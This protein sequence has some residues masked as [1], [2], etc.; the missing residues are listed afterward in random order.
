LPNGVCDSLSNASTNHSNQVT[1]ANPAQVD[2]SQLSPREILDA[3]LQR[4]KDPQIDEMVRALAAK[5]PEEISSGIE[6]EKRARSLVSRFLQCCGLTQYVLEP[7]RGDSI[8]DLVLSSVP[9]LRNVSIQPPFVSSDHNCVA[10]QIELTK[11]EVSKLPLPDFNKT[12]F[13]RLSLYL[14]SVD[15]WDALCYYASVDDLY[16]K[17]CRVIYRAW[18][19]VFPSI[20]LSHIGICSELDRHLRKFLINSE[21]HASNSVNSKAIFSLINKKMK[22]RNRYLDDESK[23]EALAKYFSSVFLATIPIPM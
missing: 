18:L 15:W 11:P 13:R 20:Q 19:C 8:L 16:R 3:I 5:L 4:N 6:A 14:D 17:F 21:K 1:G 23:A 22:A 2:Y 7:T 10:F 9:L 12:D